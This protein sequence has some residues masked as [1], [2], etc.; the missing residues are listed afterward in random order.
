M[1]NLLTVLLLCF[2]FLVS[3]GA[4]AQSVKGKVIDATNSEPLPGATI[5]VVGTNTGAISDVDGSYSV[6]GLEPGIYDLYV[7]YIGYTSRLFKDINVSGSN[8][9][10]LNVV[11]EVD[12][13][14][15][16]VITVETTLSMANEQALLIEQKNSDNVQDGISEQQ[17]KKA[18]DATAS[19]VLKRVTGISIVEDKY[20]FIRGTSERYNNTTLNGVLLP[21]T[22]PDKK[23]FS[24][25][26]FPSNLLENIIISKTFTPDQPGNYSGGLVQ[27]NTKDFPDDLTMNYSLSGG[28]NTL[29]S[30]KSFSTY[31]AS[32]KSI[33]FINLGIDDSRRLPLN[34]PRTRVK[35]NNFNRDQMR[36][37]SRSFR[38]DWAQKDVK[39]PLN[40]GFV[41]SLGNSYKLGEI[42]IGF[43]AAYSY[44]SSYSNKEI[45]RDE[46]NTDNSK[47]ISYAGN[48]SQNAVLWGGLLN[49]SAKINEYNKISL[50]ATYTLSSEDETEYYSGFVNGLS[51]SDAFDRH[52]Y[53]TR[54]VQRNLL[55]TQIFGEHVIIKLN[56]FK[57]DW[58]ASYSS[59]IRKEP[60]IKTMTYQKELGVQEP[61][62][63]AINPNFGNTY[64]GGRFFSDLTDI[65][66]SFA[67]NVEIPFRFDLP[68]ITDETSNSKFKIGSFLNGTKRDFS[69]RN[70]GVASY[71]GIP[72]SIL[73]EPIEEIFRPE[74][75]DVNKLFYDELTNETDAYTANENIYA[76]YSMLDIPISKLRFI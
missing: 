14:T 27:I 34:I 51:G 57:F 74:N 3:S 39:A 58:K 70:F 53:I 26:L 7:S 54:F 41:L 4:V 73:Y 44:K 36:D 37:I 40:T 50:K 45:E 12:G 13:I 2:T 29:T 69:A 8:V 32:N 42:P 16:D 18:P 23:A 31:N 43:L 68:F 22:D 52:L 60:D 66:K 33:F 62:Y 5:K 75:F 25:D 11:M 17:I 63:A 28:Y 24:F 56:N 61:F 9:V 19:D 55:S 6:E 30:T 67:F 47:I 59:S 38:N 46:Y 48:S 72:F 35:N 64:A 1:K 65:N 71:I 49:L 10:K 76:G 20:V 15:T 21:S